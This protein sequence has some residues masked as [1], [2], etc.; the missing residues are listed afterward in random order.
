M[1]S[2]CGDC[3]LFSMEA[4]KPK[5]RHRHLKAKKVKSTSRRG[6]RVHIHTLSAGENIFMNC[7]VRKAKCASLRFGVCSENLNI[8]RTQRQ[9][10]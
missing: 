5:P 1:R 7:P 9:A 10:G 4:R 2:S 3:S 8:H 6:R